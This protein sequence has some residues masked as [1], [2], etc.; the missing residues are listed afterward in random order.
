MQDSIRI[1]HTRHEQATS[2]MA[3]GYARTSGRV[4]VGLVVPG[5]G[6][7]NAMAG[8]STAYAC[9]SPVLSI[10]GQIETA[11]IGKGRGMLHEIPHQLE[12][13]AAVTKWAARAER[14]EDV[15][16]V[17]HL[18]MMEVRSGRPRPVHIEVPLDVLRAQGEV[19]LLEPVAPELP[20]GAPEALAA[21]AKALAGSQKPVIFAGGGVMQSGAWAELQ[22]LAELLQAPVVHSA[23][24][25]GAISDHHYLAQMPTAGKY[26][27]P[28][29]D[30]VLAVG[31]RFLQPS[32]AAWGVKGHQTVIQLDIDDEE[33]G[34]N[35][36]PT[37]R[38]QADARLGLAGLLERTERLASP[39]ASREKELRELQDQVRAEVYGDEHRAPLAMAVR[40]A[41]PEDGILVT[42]MT[43]VG[44][45][46][47]VGF[48]VYHPRSFLTAGY[49]G[50]LGYGFATALGAQ[51]ANPDKKVV[52]IS[53]DGGFMYN[54]QELS[55]AK[56]HGINLV[57]VIFND[58]A[59]GNVQ[60]IQEYQFN[61][62]TIASDLLNP[63]FV[64]LAESF[65]VVGMRAKDA[66]DLVGVLREA[67]A[68]D[69]PVLIDMPVG[70]MPPF[71]F[72]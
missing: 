68:A 5:P 1:I 63:D 32:T 28:E 27:V 54:V 6:L 44:Y 65:G 19:R 72:R 21:A 55:T 52:C 36:P 13:M 64:K 34:R 20:S 58:G 33:I 12:T 38:I 61:G 43:Q 51:V 69:A 45:W 35:Y 26:L 67:L 42:E 57:T 53:G 56:R 25:R 7:L 37:I 59:Y 49:Q 30:V 10:A 46:S 18:A 48:P 4:G 16:K 15:A 29:A 60:R 11:Q 40:E 70:K 14:P 22:Q 62:R 8:L 41:L 23:E 31:T 24:G 9:S 17:A 50:T 66:K 2:Y 39:R 47:R 3:D 71:V